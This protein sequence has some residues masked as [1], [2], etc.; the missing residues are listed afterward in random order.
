MAAA[1]TEP[2][3]GPAASPSSQRPSLS[4]NPSNPSISY[5]TTPTRTPAT[6]Q[7]QRPGPL[8][9]SIPL[10][11]VFYASASGSTPRGESPTAKVG[12]TGNAPALGLWSNSHSPTQTSKSAFLSDARRRMSLDTR[13]VH[14]DI[15]PRARQRSITVGK[16]PSVV[17]GGYESSSDDNDEELEPHPHPHPQPGRARSGSM[18]QG[19]SGGVGVARPQRGYS[20]SAMGSPLYPAHA[21]HAGVSAGPSA[22]LAG[23]GTP[24][25]RDRDM[26]P[27]AHSLHPHGIA[28]GLTAAG[29]ASPISPAA[30]EG[31]GIMNANP[32]GTRRR[33]QSLISPSIEYSPST[34]GSRR[35]SRPIRSPLSATHTPR[36]VT[37]S[38]I[39]SPIVDR[40]SE[41]RETREPRE[42]REPRE[43]RDLRDRER[44]ASMRSSRHDDLAVPTLSLPSSHAQSREGSIRE[45]GGGS[46]HRKQKIREPAQPRKRAFGAS[47]GLGAAPRE[48]VL[49]PDQLQN[50]LKNVDVSTA[51]HRMSAPPLRRVSTVNRDTSPSRRDTLVPPSPTPD[52][53][54]PSYQ[55]SPPQINK[56]FLVSAP[57]ALTSGDWSGRI[58]SDSNASSTEPTMSRNITPSTGPPSRIRT[59]S[60]SSIP[61]REHDS[62]IAI[63]AVS[64]I[65]A[66]ASDEEEAFDLGSFG[67]DAD[68][69]PG[70]DVNGSAENK[71]AAGGL[72]PAGDNEIQPLIDRDLNG[73]SPVPSPTPHHLKESSS[74]NRRRISG[75]FG[76][77]RRKREPSPPPQL[78]ADRHATP[79]RTPTP[80]KPSREQEM[81]MAEIERREEELVQG[82][83]YMLGI[84]DS[85]THVSRR[86]AGT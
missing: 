32:S 62:S 56:P 76:T 37:G 44:S 59:S 52:R 11:D 41:S 72:P 6:P 25:H 51:I 34:P 1:M 30:L 43:P 84:T 64:P 9:L 85:R 13:R 69:R 77:I 47:L 29:A 68:A 39:L 21:G 38:G 2:A 8:P 50:L 17:T 63:P 75:L 19:D 7:A 49:S 79:M 5:S 48:V 73:A 60:L 3:S 4:S 58:R 66:G 67:A 46:G 80:E 26:H 15:H 24:R 61:D 45:G 70:A 31:L 33:A 18:R 16:R 81:R 10:S 12:N 65:P 22:G 57:P 78:A 28:H 82:G 83:I 74:G 86:G 36:N 14:S 53:D 42:A 27:H 23:A 55:S 20:I 40:P 71:A 54:L 35:G